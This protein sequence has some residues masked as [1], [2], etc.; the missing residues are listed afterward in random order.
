MITPDD[1]DIDAMFSLMEA[2]RKHE[3]VIK[4]EDKEESKEEKKPPNHYTQMWKLHGRVITAFQ[5][6]IRDISPMLPPIS[7][8]TCTYICNYRVYGDV[9]F[10]MGSGNMH[11]CNERECN[12]S[13]RL[14]E[15]MMCR[16]TSNIYPLP[17]DKGLHG[18]STHLRSYQYIK[19]ESKRPKTDTKVKE[20]KIPT[21]VVV[22]QPSVSPSVLRTMIRKRKAKPAD[23]QKLGGEASSIIRKIINMTGK[24]PSDDTMVSRISNT[25]CRLWNVVSSSPLFA[26]QCTS[27]QF[28]NH[29]YIVIW[30]T[31]NGFNVDKISIVR[32]EPWM[33]QYLPVRQVLTTLLKIPQG[34]LTETEKFFKRCINDLRQNNKLSMLV[35]SSISHSLPPEPVSIKRRRVLLQP[36]N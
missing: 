36:M 17:L 33:R 8:H 31:I 35:A 11:I 14:M 24:S 7:P 29:C 28:T 13:I 6:W 30:N 10:C 22:S 4:E 5:S 25:C 21:R 23:L 1:P 16:L 3:I 34:R 20:V 18:R 32:Q 15:G 19:K 9:Y 12:S 2:S 27:Y 26:R